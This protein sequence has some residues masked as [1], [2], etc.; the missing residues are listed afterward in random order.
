MANNKHYPAGT[1]KGGQFMEKDSAAVPGEGEDENSSSQ[2]PAKKRVVKK[3]PKIQELENKGG[4]GAFFAQLQDLNSTAQV[5]LLNDENEIE[6]NIEK[7][8]SKNVTTHIDRL[9][10]TTSSCASYQFHPKSNSRVNLN[11]F[12]CVFGKYRYPDNHAKLISQ[13]EYDRLSQDSANYTRVY[14]GFSSEGEKRKAIINGYTTADVNNIDV[15]GN[16]VYGTN[17]YTSVDYS[18]SLSY[19]NYDSSKVLYC[20]V[21]KNAKYIDDVSLNKI[22]R[23]LQNNSALC[24]SI[25]DKTKNQLIKNGVAEDRADRISKSFEKSLTSDDSLLAILLGYD[26][27]ISSGRSQRNILNL[28]KWLINKERLGY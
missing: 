16:G 10:G 11:L 28:K 14:R 6:Q 21:D 19:A 3:K 25:I 22:Q 17:I 24:Q 4:F 13:E 23:K 5:G 12:T 1:S 27:Q 2:T 15:Y 18:Y 9:Y 26:Y 7:F 20:L 8:W